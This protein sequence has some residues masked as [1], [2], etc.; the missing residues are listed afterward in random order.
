MSLE[1]INF[2]LLETS[3]YRWSQISEKYFDDDKEIVE[4]IK[5]KIDDN[6]FFK[7]ADV[8]KEI[9]DQEEQVKKVLF[10]MRD[11]NMIS[12]NVRISVSGLDIKE[13]NK[14]MDGFEVMDQMKE[15]VAFCFIGI[16]RTFFELDVNKE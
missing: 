15:V 1:A 10:V 5:L 7:L 16:Y 13:I 9:E 12:S 6:G 2:G 11:L 3:K 8:L 4:V 14:D